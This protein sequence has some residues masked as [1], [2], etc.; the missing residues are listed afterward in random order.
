MAENRVST[1]ALS[2]MIKLYENLLKDAATVEVDVDETGG[3]VPLD[4]NKRQAI[5]D[6]LDAASKAL[7]LGCQQGVYGLFVKSK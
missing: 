7:V 5:L 2:D 6:S 3:R 1:R 4:P